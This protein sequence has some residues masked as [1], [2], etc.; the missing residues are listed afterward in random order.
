[1]V[2][3]GSPLD[4][5]TAMRQRQ[6]GDDKS[7]LYLGLSYSKPTESIY[8]PGGSPISQIHSQDEHF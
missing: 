8:P 4:P 1:M 3:G 6:L 2:I 5:V 7:N